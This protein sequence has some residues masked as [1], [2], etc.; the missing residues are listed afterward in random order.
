VSETG[1]DAPLGTDAACPPLE[2]ADLAGFHLLSLSL[3]VAPENPILYW[4]E[5]MTTNDEL[6]ETLAFIGGALDEVDHATPVGDPVSLW[7][8]PIVDGKLYIEPKVI[9]VPGQASTLVGVKDLAMTVAFHGTVCGP[10]HFYC[11]ELSGTV[12]EPLPMDLA[13]STFTLEKGVT[14]E[15]LPSPIHVDC[16]KNLAAF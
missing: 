5:A 9:V 7:T 13:G 14:D 1:S 4:G 12:E 3:S 15:Q 8:V 16:A 2:N 11:G 6:G 10:S